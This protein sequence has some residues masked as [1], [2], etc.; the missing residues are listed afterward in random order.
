MG[1]NNNVAAVLAGKQN[2]AAVLI[3]EQVR[4]L[5]AET[6]PSKSGCSAPVTEKTEPYSPFQNKSSTIEYALARLDDL[7]NWG[8]KGI[9]KFII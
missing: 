8:R 4:K 7:L 1:R 5:A 9:A 2:P 6:A 3:T